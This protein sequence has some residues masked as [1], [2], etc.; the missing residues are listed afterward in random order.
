MNRVV[1][2]DHLSARERLELV[3]ELWDQIASRPD[4]VP[5]TDAQ[6]GELDR[7]LAD[8][9]SAPNEVTTWDAVKARK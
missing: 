5:V 4:D 3:Q 1:D 8:H 7:R 6:R 2:L 9:Q